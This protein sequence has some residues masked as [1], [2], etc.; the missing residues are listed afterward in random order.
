MSYV[1]GTHFCRRDSLLVFERVGE[2]SRKR[3]RSRSS[4]K[5]DRMHDRK[6]IRQHP[7]YPYLV[8]ALLL[9]VLVSV[10]L[11]FAQARRQVVYGSLGTVDFVEYWSAGQLFREGHNPYD[12]EKLHRLQR[13]VGSRFDMPII[14]WNPPWLLLWLYPLLSLPFVDAALVWLA[15]NLGILFTSSALVWRTYAER[16]A[17]APVVIAWLALLGFAPA[18]IAVRMGQMS[19]L[20]LL[21]TAGFI[22]FADRQ[23]GFLAGIFLALTTIK[24]HVVYLLWI[25]VAW[26]VFSG[27]RWKVLGGVAAVLAP[28]LGLLTIMWPDWLTVYSN[29]LARPPLYWQTPTLGGVLREFVFDANPQAQ[30][31][32]AITGALGWLGLL[33]IKRPRICWRSLAGPLLLISVPTAAYGWSFDQSVLLLPYL[34][35]VAWLVAADNWKRGPR[36]WVLASLVAIAAVTVSQ[37]LLGIRELF[38]FWVP[39][40]FGAVYLYAQWS[41]HGAARKQLARGGQR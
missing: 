5:A 38:F 16:E 18:L 20:I 21:G 26:W 1:R 22:Y 10:A 15:I 23:R 7:L 39:F 40:A 33:L 2:L 8:A 37:N 19:S 9:A 28:S 36:V 27:K 29:V 41:R 4:K 30:Y 6:P 25:G 35:M 13:D 14:M 17:E 11:L 12:F 3:L 34:Q 24:P 32:P 31:L